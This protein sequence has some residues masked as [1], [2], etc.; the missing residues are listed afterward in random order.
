V[1][2]ILVAR[3]GGSLEDL[4]AFNDERVVRAIAFSPV[5]VI[6]GIGH[7]TDFTLSDF[8]S[9]LRAPTPTGAAVR[10]VPDRVDLASEL[11]SLQSRLGS[12][13]LAWV[14]DHWQDLDTA[15]Q[16][17]DRSSPD[18][19]IRN[20]RQKL[21]EWRERSMR[22][23]SHLLSLRTAHLEGMH[24]RLYSLNPS[25]ILKRGF[26]IVQREDGTPVHSVGQVQAGEIT[27]TLLLDG[28]LVSR[29]DQVQP[30]GSAK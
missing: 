5:P 8:A 17:L 14:S 15:R 28:T 2:V 27:R 25:S 4:W 26:A 6:T 29:I 16:R 30:G 18:W 23:M 9:D 20:E 24:N 11:F 19:R 22:G 21:D 10:A 13:L 1:D 7:E 3:G 12:A